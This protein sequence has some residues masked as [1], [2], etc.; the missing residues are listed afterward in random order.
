MSNLSNQKDKKAWNTPQLK[1]LSLTQTKTDLT[2]DPI[3]NPESLAV[4]IDAYYQPGS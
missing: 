3:S 2:P 4:G 1:K